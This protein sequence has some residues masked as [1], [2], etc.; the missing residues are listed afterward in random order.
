VLSPSIIPIAPPP[1]FFSPDG[2]L[3][4]SV[5]AADIGIYALQSSSGK[6]TASTLLPISGSV[7]VATATLH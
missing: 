6:L 4:Y 3:V 2:K 7:S 5:N 1:L